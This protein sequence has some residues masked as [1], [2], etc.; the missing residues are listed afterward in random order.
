MPTKDKRIDAYIAK[1]Q[2]FAKPILTHL[3]ELVHKACPDCE[4]TLKW[5][6]PSFIYNGKI[7]A[8]V[9]SFKQHAVFG[10]W[11]QKLMKDPQ[12]LF[13]A[14]D[15]AMGSIGRLTDISDLPKDRVLLSYIKESMRVID[16]GETRQPKH[17]PKKKEPLATPDFLTKA[18]KSNT[19][20][21]KQFEAFSPSK[22]REYVEWLTEAKTEAT[23]EKR[24]E[25]AL[26][27]IAEGKGRNWK[28][29]RKK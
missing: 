17:P 9:A 29:E 23:R 4:E 3:R 10:F 5:S 27:W 15:T 26:E 12:G 14:P 1:A 25:Q 2:P 6:M 18:L 11:N 19:A 13:Q 16:S 8:G 21:R 20:A 7:L 22:K 24:L 28:Y